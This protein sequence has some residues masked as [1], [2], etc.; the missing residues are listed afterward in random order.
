M[1]LQE[2]MA[3]QNVGSSNFETKWHL[4]PNPMDNHK[5][6][7][8]KG[9]VVV[10]PSLGRGESCESMYARDLFVHQKCSNYALTN[11]LFGLY[12]SMWII[13]PLVTHH[14]PHLEAPTH[15]STFKVFWAKECTPTLSSSIIS[16][17]GFIFESFKECEGASH[18]LQENKHKE[19]KKAQTIW[20]LPIFI[21]Y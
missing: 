12:K 9:K 16:T 5:K 20:T 19:K 17:F 4:D 18:D 1:S 7:Y 2:V 8:I 3:I 11:F 15:P 6:Y 13:D 21:N 10:P 14:S